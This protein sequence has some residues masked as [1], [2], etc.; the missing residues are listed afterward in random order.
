MGKFEHV[1]GTV[2]ILVRWNPTVLA[3]HTF[4]LYVTG[5]LPRSL[6]YF[7]DITMLG[8]A[9]GGNR[10]EPGETHGI[11]HAPEELPCVRPWRFLGL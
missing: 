2:S 11:A 7:T 8:I 10:T 9:L 5:V 3:S 6:K 4:F 1:S